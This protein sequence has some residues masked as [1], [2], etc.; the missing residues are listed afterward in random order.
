MFF[1]P[2]T[3]V[4]VAPGHN[5]LATA[6]QRVYGTLATRPEGMRDTELTM[7]CGFD[8]FVL[9]GIPWWEF[10]RR[11]MDPVVELV[12]DRGEWKLKLKSILKSIPEFPSISKKNILKIEPPPP[13]SVEKKE[14]YKESMIIL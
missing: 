9:F 11:H 14:R 7:A 13:P 6:V 3:V 1:R 2:P 8:P 10:V 4:P 12:M 5:S